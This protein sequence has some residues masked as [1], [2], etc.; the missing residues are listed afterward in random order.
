MNDPFRIVIVG[1]GPRALGLLERFIAIYPEAGIDHPVEIHMIDPSEAGRGAHPVQQSDTLLTNTVA[2]QITLFSDS[3]VQDAGPV[4]P[5]PSLLDWARDSG[6]RRIGRRFV[7]SGNEGE[8]IDENDYLPRNLLG[9]Y[10]SH[11]Y[12]L[13]SQRLPENM[14]LLHPRRKVENIRRLENDRYAISMEGGYTLLADYV[15]LATGHGTNLPDETQQQLEHQLNALRARNHKLQHIATP[16]PLAGLPSIDADAVVGVRGMGL[17][18]H[19]V[20]SELTE[21]RGGR[22]IETD[23]QLHYQPSGRE[24]KIVLFSRQ[25]LPYCAR[26]SNQKGVS[27]Q[28]QA[29][30]FTRMWIDQQRDRQLA[31]T[32][33]RQLDFAS[34]LWP[35][36]RLE[37]AHMHALT[38]LGHPPLADAPTV[39]VAEE[40]F[41]AVD[42][43]MEPLD[44]TRF[45][46]QADYHAAVM[47]YLR[48]DLAHAEQGNVDDPIKAATDILRDVR[49][50]LRYAVDFGGLSPASHRDFLEQFCPVMNRI[51]VGPPLSRNRELL[52]L[53]EAGIVSFGPGPM[54]TLRLDEQ[55]ARFVLSS[56]QLEQ[57]QQT[58]FDVLINA[59]IDMFYPR[60]DRSL[61]MRNMLASGTIRPYLHGDF[62]PGG[63]DIDPFNRLIDTGGTVHSRL[64]ALGNPAEGPNFYTFILP[65]PMVNSRSIQ[66]AGRCATQILTGIRLQTQQ[67]QV[68]DESV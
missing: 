47:D 42:R 6:Y 39:E 67:S 20:I 30:F 23:G 2:G 50:N 61:L 1:G 14:K 11:V 10:L 31:T 27:G 48:T 60:Q 53:I 35:R 25:G 9:L 64:W 51:A 37:M 55:Q 3:S 17:T 16:Y 8:I 66:D 21:G 22:F 28:W 7:Q 33:C 34:V 36:I 24:P 44:D 29:R 52:C 38:R 54:P 65:R 41:A 26:G 62:H 15:I 46:G 32:G 40:D 56:T 43:L 45:D 58:T 18:A 19:D 5:G 12:D 4:V 49:D 57:P 13:L 59:R 63:L 68:A